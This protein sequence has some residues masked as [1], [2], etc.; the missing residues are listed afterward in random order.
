LKKHVTVADLEEDD[1]PMKLRPGRRVRESRRKGEQT[2]VF[3]APDVKDMEETLKTM[4]SSTRQRVTMEE[5]TKAYLHGAF[6]KRHP[7]AYHAFSV[8]NSTNAPVTSRIFRYRTRHVNL[9]EVQEAN[10]YKPRFSEDTGHLRAKG[11]GEICEADATGGRL[12]LMARRGDHLVCIGKCHIYL[13][14]D[15]WSRFI[16]GIHI[17]LPG[18]TSS[19]ELSKAMEYAFTARTERYARL[20]I[21]VSEEDW[22]RSRI[23]T[24]LITDRGPEYLSH[25]TVDKVT[26]D[27]GIKHT[28]LRAYFPDGKATIE[29]FI[30][31]LKNM[32]SQELQGAFANAIRDRETKIASEKAREAAILTIEDAYRHAVQIVVHYNNRIHRGLSKMAVLKQNG[33]LC[34]P[35]AAY[36]WGLANITGLRTPRFSDQQFARLLLTTDVS[37]RLR[38]GVMFHKTFDYVPADALAMEV[39]RET[40]TKSRWVKIKADADKI[41]LYMIV[42]ANR[43]A[44][45]RATAATLAALGK[46]SPEEEEARREVNSDNAAEHKEQQMRRPPSSPGAPAATPKALSVRSADEAEKRDLRAQEM[47]ALHRKLDGR[48]PAPPPTDPTTY[49]EADESN[50]PLSDW[51]QRKQ[52]KDADLLRR[53]RERQSANA[54]KAA[55]EKPQ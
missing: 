38:G 37:A 34:T 1:A 26:K 4:L 12:W 19:A 11:P 54:T 27:L 30:R 25:A 42:G 28:P 9:T 16:H 3:D 53:F 40:P 7:Q 44:H 13:F 5:M 39:A 15:R 14:M 52:S 46:M 43:L 41:N 48:P 10:L 22:P 32:M 8:L 17:T 21:S 2:V 33:V 50:V 36:L 20:G 55:H 24:E 29:R 31:T 6:A 51:E 35:K 18:K 23:P 45:F 47:D 49:Q